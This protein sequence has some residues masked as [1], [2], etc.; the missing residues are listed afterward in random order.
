MNERKMPYYSKLP[1]AALL[2][3][4]LFFSSFVCLSQPLMPH[5]SSKIAKKQFDEKQIE[6]LKNNPDLQYTT[7]QNNNN[8]LW[9]RLMSIFYN[10]LDEL[11]ANPESRQIFKVVI[12]VISTLLI[13]YAILKIIGVDTASL[14]TGRGQAKA[15]GSYFSEKDIHHINFE[16]EIEKAISDH[17]YRLAVRLLYLKNLK[18]LAD[19]KKV[20]WKPHKTNADYLREI[21]AGTLKN[22]F[23]DIT[24]VFDY[25][26]YGN[27]QIDEPM[28]EKAKMAFAQ[29]EN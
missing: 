1:K 7:T 20:D 26:W 28:F 5:D 21:P 9:E 13:I 18:Y 29:F 4:L 27:F 19:T 15:D 6:A 22:A 3:I 2:V 24:Y 14:L 16:K 8:S 23:A 11:F 10:W 17:N 25:V 12:N